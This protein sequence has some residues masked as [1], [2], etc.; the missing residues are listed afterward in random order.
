MLNEIC[1]DVRSFLRGLASDLP[2]IFPPVRVV[3]RAARGGRPVLPAASRKKAK[4]IIDA[5]VKYW[6]GV[7]GLEYG[8]VSVKDQ[9]TLWGSCSRKKNLNFNWRLA[10]APRETLDYVV[11]H[12][13][14]HLREMNHSGKFW[15]HVGAV[16]PDYA[17]R[18]KWL[19]NNSSRLMGIHGLCNDPEDVKRRGDIYA[20]F[21]N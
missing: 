12:E 2:E 19:K 6:A 10:A 17:A 8:R 14:C 7:M 13:L 3:R 18:K 21:D 16:C 20:G 15:S 5:R 9:R 4:D 11:I 1:R